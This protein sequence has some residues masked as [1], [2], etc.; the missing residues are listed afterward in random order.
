MFVAPIFYL[1]T[2]AV[3]NPEPRWELPQT[4]QALEIW[5]GQTTPD[6]PVFAALAAD[7]KTAKKTAPQPSRQA[8]EL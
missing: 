8:T 5:D 1:L 3:G 6:E 2:T 4:L 7:L